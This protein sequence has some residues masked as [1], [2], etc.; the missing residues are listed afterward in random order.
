MARLVDAWALGNYLQAIDFKDAIVDAI[1]QKVNRSGPLV[2]QTMHQIVYPKSLSGTLIRRLTVDIAAYRWDT[3]Y[4]KLQKID[5][6]WSDFFLD[7]SVVLSDMRLAGSTSK[8]QF[9]TNPCA[10]HEH[11]IRNTPC[12]KTKVK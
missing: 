9:E 10:Y 12:Y 5:T 7:L 3:R 4:L 8:P 6:D 2:P 1:I 11:R